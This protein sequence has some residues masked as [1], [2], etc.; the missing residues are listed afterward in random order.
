MSTF[1]SDAVNRTA[2]PVSRSTITTWLA[3]VKRI[4]RH[5]AHL[6]QARLTYRRLCELD[7]RTLKDI[8]LCRSGLMF[9]KHREAFHDMNEISQKPGHRDEL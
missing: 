5:I 6:H 3:T 8:G 9:Y 7:D 4:M 2:S 1:F